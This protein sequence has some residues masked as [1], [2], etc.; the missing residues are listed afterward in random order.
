MSYRVVVFSLSDRLPGMGD[1]LRG[2]QGLAAHFH[3]TGDRR[4]AA[5]FRAF[6]N[7]RPFGFRQYPDHLPQGMARGCG[8]V[9]RFRQRAEG[10]APRFQI[11]QEADQVTQRPTQSVEFRP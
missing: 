8:G 1:L 2:Q 11:I 7:Q 9:Y 3:P 5:R 6:L 4:R 10:H